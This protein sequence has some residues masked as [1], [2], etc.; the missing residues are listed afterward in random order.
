[1]WLT[2]NEGKGLEE[3]VIH[4]AYRVQEELE[5]GAGYRPDGDCLNGWQNR[6]RETRQRTNV[7]EGTCHMKKKKKKK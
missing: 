7:A 1:M 3:F 2:P 6:R 5:K 4:M